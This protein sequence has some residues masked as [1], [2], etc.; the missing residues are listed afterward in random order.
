MAAKRGSWGPASWLAVAG[1]AAV[2]CLVTTGVAL[3]VISAT[4][5]V[6]RGG[7]IE[8]TSGQIVVGAGV[9]GSVISV[10][11]WQLLRALASTTAAYKE[12][13]PVAT[14]LME[15]VRSLEALVRQ[16]E[17][18]VGEAADGRGNGRRSI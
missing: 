15:T 18:R 14:A 8:L 9:L 4:E 10:L 6:T 7:S 11:F 5:D 13:L 2:V 16:L 1:V 17:R 3:G 12:V